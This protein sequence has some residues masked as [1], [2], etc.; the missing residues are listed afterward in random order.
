V[1]PRSI[2]AANRRRAAN[3]PFPMAYPTL[4]GATFSAIEGAAVRIVD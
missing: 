4:H 2:E 1:A 3:T